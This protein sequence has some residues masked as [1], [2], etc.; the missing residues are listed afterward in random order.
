[1]FWGVLIITP[2]LLK[3]K[4]YYWQTAYRMKQAEIKAEEVLNNACLA[5][6]G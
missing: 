6:Y 2:L 1:V 3:T 4:E 5:L